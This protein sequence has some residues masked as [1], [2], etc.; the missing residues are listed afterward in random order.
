VLM[1]H[2]GHGGWDRYRESQEQ[3]DGDSSRK[4]VVL[5]EHDDDEN[6]R[7]FKS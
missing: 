7:R 6:D 3:G 4:R 2:G 1:G 5:A